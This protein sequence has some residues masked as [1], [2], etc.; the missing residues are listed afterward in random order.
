MNGPQLAPASPAP[1]AMRPTAELLQEG[2]GIGLRGLTERL[3]AMRAA[4]EAVPAAPQP[5]EE[6]A[7]PEVAAAEPPA[8]EATEAPGDEPDTEAAD[9]S[10]D[11]GTSDEA[12]DDAAEPVITLKVNG[13]EK[14]VSFAET[15]ELAEKGLSSQSRWQEAA[16]IR[17]EGE[18]LQQEAESLRGEIEARKRALDEIIALW[19]IPEPDYGKLAEDPHAFAQYEAQRRQYDAKMARVKEAREV[20]AKRAEDE[21]IKQYNAWAEKEREALL[22]KLPNWRNSQAEQAARKELGDY[23]L[24]V[25]YRDDELPHIHDHRLILLMDKARKFDEL[26]K[27]KPKVENKVRKAPPAVKPT[28]A[29]KPAEDRQVANVRALKANVAGQHGRNRMLAGAALI[30]AIRPK[31]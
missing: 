4:Q 5:Q 27:A 8:D 18:R 21:Q 24:S 23:A 17:R 11:D 28:V 26:Q 12:D 25:G 3:Q 14:V 16:A 2:Q 19:Q 31:P 13:R 29:P 7:Q 20:E 22:D 30:G 6:Q 1:P 9:E 10:S 15:L